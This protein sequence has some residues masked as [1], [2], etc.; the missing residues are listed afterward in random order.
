MKMLKVAII[1]TGRSLEGGGGAERRFFSAYKELKKENVNIELVLNQN[2]YYS[3]EKLKLLDNNDSI[4][5]IKE[6]SNIKLIAYN[7]HIIYYLL[8]ARPATVH[9]PLIQ[10]SLAPVYI[11]LTLARSLLNI[12]TTCTIASYRHA[13]R[14]DLSLSDKLIYFLFLK[15][16]D[17]LDSLYPKIKI[18]KKFFIT[19]CS[20]INYD[21]FTPL[22]KENKVVFLGRF[23]PEK[24][25]MLFLEAIN[26]V[27]NKHQH[28]K[29]LK[30]MFILS[31]D[32]PLKPNIQKFISLNNLDKKVIISKGDPSSLLGKSKI[33]VSIQEHENYPSQSLLEAIACENIIIA[34]NVGDT[35]YLL[36]DAASS[37]L[38]SINSNDLALALEKAIE[39]EKH[40]S[41]STK[42]LRN[43]ILQNHNLNIFVEYLIKLWG[44][45]R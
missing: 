14:V 44:I 37:I 18:N 31:G 4:V 40:L 16:A 13:Y 11:F 34:T 22:E 8:T 21:K 28:D 42:S 23:V 20:F 39:H 2:L 5:L 30:W 38:I 35:K 43:Y 7:I 3:A 27:L 15:C 9:F 41:S 32:G 33:F 29:A 1:L 25:P 10:K 6:R 26:I 45:H 12:T 24:N 36:N 19:P 17:K